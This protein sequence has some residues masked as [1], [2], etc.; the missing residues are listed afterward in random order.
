MTA[1]HVFFVFSNMFF[2]LD[3]SEFFF[4]EIFLVNSHF[5]S[6]FLFIVSS[7]VPLKRDK[8]A[9]I[10]EI[11]HFYEAMILIFFVLL[12]IVDIC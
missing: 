11:K 5:F 6:L 9:K 1:G 10:L 4:R 2:L 8:F 7:F 3:F 12:F